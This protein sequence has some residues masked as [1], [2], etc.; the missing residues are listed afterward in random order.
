MKYYGIVVKKVEIVV[1]QKPVYV[2]YGCPYCDESI[3]IGVKEFCGENGELGE[4]DTIEC[5][6]CGNKIKVI[7]TE[8]IKS[9]KLGNKSLSRWKRGKYE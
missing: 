7:G 4:I 8:W 6:E 9:N 1:V 2:V 3:E 5:P